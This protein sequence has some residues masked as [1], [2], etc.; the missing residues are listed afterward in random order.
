VTRWTVV[1]EG[2]PV[3]QPRP[4]VYGTHTV[5]DSTKSRVW[6]QQVKM[7]WGA[8]PKYDGPV[9]LRLTFFMPRP[10]RLMRKKDPDKAIPAPVRPD[11][12]NLA[13]AV[14][15]ALE[16]LAFDNDSQVVGLDLRKLYPGK[17]DPPGVLIQAIAWEDV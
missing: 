4:R 12:D 7:A 1:V 6:K 17:G 13:K 15:D 3:A 10:K 16:G 5:S 11:L 9:C 14:L 2:V 8:G